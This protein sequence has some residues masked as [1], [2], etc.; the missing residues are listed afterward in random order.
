[1]GYW[2]GVGRGKATLNICI[3][4]QHPQMDQRK[5]LLSLWASPAKTLSCPWIWGSGV[6]EWPSLCQTMYIHS[7][8]HLVPRFNLQNHKKESLLALPFF[9]PL[10]NLG[11]G[12]FSEVFSFRSP[13]TSPHQGKK[14][15]Q[16]PCSCLEIG[17]WP[18][19]S[20]PWAGDPGLLSTW[21]CPRRL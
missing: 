10:Y 16:N 3:H 7:R 4:S 19:S 12:Y 1:M 14:I 8:L 17:P 20:H 6:L 2:G 21:P 18:A 5:T 13:F 11:L 9:Q 15:K